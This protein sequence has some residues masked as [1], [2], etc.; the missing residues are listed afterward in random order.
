M[1]YKYWK[2]AAGILCLAPV[3]AVIGYLLWIAIP[4]AVQAAKDIYNSPGTWLILAI[5]FGIITMAFLLS[6]GMSFIE[7]FKFDSEM[8][9]TLKKN[10]GPAVYKQYS[11]YTSLTARLKRWIHGDDKN[12]VL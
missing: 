7:G 10:L 11:E 1:R 8:D 6:A 4:M 2:L 3:V 12:K 9:K 5:F